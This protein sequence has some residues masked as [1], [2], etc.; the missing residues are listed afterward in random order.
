MFHRF[1]LYLWM[2]IKYSQPIAPAKLLMP[3]VFSGSWAGLKL[4]GVSW[5]IAFVWAAVCAQGV[6]IWLVLLPIIRRQRQKTG[7]A[8]VAVSVVLAIWFGA[9]VAQVWWSEPWFSQRLLSVC[10]ALYAVILVLGIKRDGDVMKYFAPG[11]NDREV[12]P[13]FRRRLL[14]L[15]ALTAVFVIAVNESL[16]VTGASL[17][18][19]VAILSLMPLFLHY[20]FQMVFLLTAPPLRDDET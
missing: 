18:L 12:S 6:H 14:Q 15:Y 5:P 11:P 16:L 13:E 8:R 20:V 9:L 1:S 7:S 4:S 3:F 19:T 2:L 17:N 10:C